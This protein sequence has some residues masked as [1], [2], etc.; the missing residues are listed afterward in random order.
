MEDAVHPDNDYTGIAGAEYNFFTC[1]GEMKF[2][3]TEP[4]Y[5]TFTFGK[6]DEILNW[7]KGE[8]GI[9]HGH[10]LIWY[11]AN[12]KW[13]F[14]LNATSPQWAP[15]ALKLFLLNHI[16]NVLAHWKGQIYAW[17]VV[18]EAISGQKSDT[19][20]W[21]NDLRYKGT[22]YYDDPWADN[23]GSDYIEIAFQRAR[24]DDPS[25]I[26]VYNDYNQEE[27]NTKSNIEYS[28][29]KDF[30]GRGI[31]VDAVGFQ[32][33]WNDRIPDFNSF[34]TNMDRFAKLGLKIFI[35]ELDTK[36]PNGVAGNVPNAPNDIQARTYY[37]TLDK[38]L[39]QPAVIGFQICGV[40]DRYSWL[41]TDSQGN[42]VD[43][44]ALPF[45]DWYQGYYAKPAYYGLQDALN[46]QYRTE[47]LVNGGFENG[48]ASWATGGSGTLTVVADAHSGANAAKSV[49]RTAS[50]GGMQQGI[51]SALTTQGA[52]RYYLSGWA[53]FASG[54]GTVR[55]SLKTA[56]GTTA[57]PTSH[58]V[59]VSGTAGTAWTHIAGWVNVTW[60]VALTS[61]L[62]QVDTPGTTADFFLD[63]V[64]VGDGNVLSN[65]NFENGLNGWTGYSGS[66]ISATTADAQYHYGLG[67]VAATNRAANIQGPSQDILKVLQ[68]QGAGNYN[69]ESYMKLASG[70]GNG[71]VNL[72]LSYGG[73]DHLINVATGAINSTGWTKV[74]PGS[75][76]SVTWTGPLTAAVLY[77]DTTPGTG[78]GDFYADEVLMRQ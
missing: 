36:N 25:A 23:I 42:Y 65:G 40:N 35:T 28:M 16:D 56:G 75:P 12:P 7:A 73:A 10:N 52:G 45:D 39:R 2:G 41:D 38:A 66:A 58:T 26:L 27:V 53:K 68:S 67:G 57:V 77:L 69:F 17:D 72:K 43:E 8:G 32:C 1:E 50:Y 62:V 31:P 14:D 34:A 55:I 78:T 76:V 4:S 59:S 3:G 11:T 47:T 5:N 51:T 37:G 9:V 29:I 49:G 60:D 22:E 19:T 24:Q 64:R 33:H 70:T 15:G 61:A 44:H 18:N 30:L 46:N 48:T 74:A 63:D 71:R 21:R 13:V 54:S 6:G 20:N